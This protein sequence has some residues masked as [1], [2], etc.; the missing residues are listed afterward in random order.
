[1]SSSNPLVVN[2]FRSLPDSEREQALE[3]ALALGVY[4]LSQDRIASFLAKTESDLGVQ[5]EALKQLYDTNQLRQKSSVLKGASGETSVALALSTFVENRRLADEIQLISSTAG[6]LRRNKT[7]DIL[8]HVSDDPAVPKIVI[9]VKLD[10]S[11]RLGDPSLDGLTNGKSDTAWSQLVEA[12]ANR[13]ADIALMVFS[14][15]S[16]D[17]TIGSFTD[18][19]RYIAG[20]GYIVVVDVARGDYRALT[21]AYELARE[22]VLS[23]QR[24]HLNSEVL[25]VLVR[26]LCA[27]LASAISIKSSLTSAINSCNSALSQV[28]LA[29]SQAEATQAALKSYIGTGKLDQQQLLQLLVP[30]K[31]PTPEFPNSAPDH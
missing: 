20:V 9:E 7:G 1:M 28:D 18:S 23:A 5:L 11:I 29:L 26:K 3:R 15:D 13:S 25:Q 2:Y 22:Q 8:C 4:A 21:I 6:T 31:V 17:R 12:K 19:V 27:D 24:E 16:T 10:K 14:A 30:H